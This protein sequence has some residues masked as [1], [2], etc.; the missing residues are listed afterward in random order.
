MKQPSDQAIAQ[1]FG[2]LVCVSFA[3]LSGIVTGVVM[4]ECGAPKGVDVQEFHDAVWWEIGGGEYELIQGVKSFEIQH[5]KTDGD[6]TE[7][8]PATA[9]VTPENTL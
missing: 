4:N 2:I 1:F 9:Q 8:M 6:Q 7:S 5:K 3:I